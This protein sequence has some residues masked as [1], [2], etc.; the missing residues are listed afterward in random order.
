M[1]YFRLFRGINL[2]IVALTQYLLQKVVQHSISQNLSTKLVLNNLQFFIFVLATVCVTA[3]GYIINDIYDIEIDA[4]NKPL[5]KQIVGRKISKRDAFILYFLLTALGGVLSVEVAHS[6]HHFE[7][8]WLYPTFVLSLWLYAARLKKSA[9]I[10]KGRPPPS[11]TGGGGVGFRQ[12]PIQTDVDSTL[13]PVER[14][15]D[16]CSPV[17]ECRS[18]P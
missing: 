2:T 13:G 9:E 12:P 4:Q 8:L 17:L 1:I 16:R 11:Q 18:S 7:Q 14:R 10:C 15:S 3:A 6:I 5:E